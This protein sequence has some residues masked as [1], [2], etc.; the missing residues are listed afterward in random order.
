MFSLLPPLTTDNLITAQVQLF[1]VQDCCFR[2][3]FSSENLRHALCSLLPDKTSQLVCTTALSDIFLCGFVYKPIDLDGVV[4][5][6]EVQRKILKKIKASRYIHTDLLYTKDGNR[7][8]E[9]IQ[10][11]QAVAQDGYLFLKDFD[12]NNPYSF[13]LDFERDKQNPIFLKLCAHTPMEFYITSDADTIDA[14]SVGDK[15]E[16]ENSGEKATFKIYRI[17][18][19]PFASG[20]RH[21]TFVLQAACRVS[22][23]CSIGQDTSS[24]FRFF[25]NSGAA[26]Q[27]FKPGSIFYYQD[28]IFDSTTDRL[29]FVITLER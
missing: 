10:N 6:D 23:N 14:L 22:D 9:L 29:P 8:I 21:N 2:G 15:L 12:F 18:P 20:N 17:T 7:L 11:G 1:P 25:Y 28:K 3:S 26:A 19:L 13:T 5:F 16:I 24:V 27:F 4:V